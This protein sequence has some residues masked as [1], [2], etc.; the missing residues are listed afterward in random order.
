[1]KT[2]TT[3]DRPCKPSSILYESDC[4]T[5]VLLDIPRTLEESQALSSRVPSRVPPASTRRIIS[6][7]P[8]EAPFDT[9]D[10]KSKCTPPTAATTNPASQ[11]AHLMTAAAA[12]SALDRLHTSYTGPFHLPRLVAHGEGTP[13]LPATGG[14]DP[15]IPD[16]A[17]ALHGSLQDLS[18]TLR[19]SA[20]A[21]DLIV[22][23]P[24]WPNRSARRRTDGYSTVSSLADMATLLDR[25]PVPSHLAP[26]G[27]VAV[28]I[29]NNA[30]VLDFVTSRSGLFASWGLELVAEWTWLKV[31]A[32]G[33][34]IFALDSAWR[35]PWEKLL[36]AKRVGARVP[37]EL[38]S[39]SKTIIAV[40]DVHSRKPNLRGLFTD[41]LGPGFIG[42]EVFAR[43]LTAG[44]WSWGDEVLQFQQPEHW[45]ASNP[46][47]Q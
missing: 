41:V 44:W 10:P 31:T 12:Q 29:T 11:I 46:A 26:G 9:P 16:K 17:T 8:V 24:P 45:V 37:V 20:P 3:S 2:P 27:L 21:F 47:E 6:A 35:K 14:E 32:S 40:P 1:M 4:G 19:D 43:N 30:S 23:D 38:G 25:V 18:Q 5:I 22:L 13:P 33:E 36:I 42:L 7:Q 39:S 34:P 15:F 28:W